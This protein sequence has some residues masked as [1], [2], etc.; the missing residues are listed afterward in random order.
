FEDVRR[1]KCIFRRNNPTTGASARID[2]IRQIKL[3]IKSISTMEN[4][5]TSNSTNPANVSYRNTAVR[6]GAIWGGVSILLTLIAFLTNTDPGMPETSGM[7]KALYSVVGIGAAIWAVVMAIKQ[8]RDRE[9]GGSITLGR[10]IMVGLM[11]GLVAGAIGAVFM[12]LY[13]SVIN[14]DT[15]NR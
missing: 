7:M 2:F 4:F 3:F 10:A 8:H 1:V 11:A 6:Y 13:T 14:P 15:Q 9:L 12:L 5:D